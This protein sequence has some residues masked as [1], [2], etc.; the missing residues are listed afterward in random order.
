MASRKKSRSLFHGLHQ[1]LIFL[2]ADTFPGSGTPRDARGLHVPGYLLAAVPAI[3]LGLVRPDLVSGIA[4][5]T[6]DILRIRGPY[7]SASWASFFQHLN[8]SL[9]ESGEKTMR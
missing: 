1:P 3:N 6:D 8:I 5:E 7:L 2:C 9:A 4:P